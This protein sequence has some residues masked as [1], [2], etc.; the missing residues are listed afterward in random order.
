MGR[1]CQNGKIFS[2]DVLL[3]RDARTPWSSGDRRGVSLAAEGTVREKG[4]GV[5]REA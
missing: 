1:D 5:R 4:D 2:A 3:N